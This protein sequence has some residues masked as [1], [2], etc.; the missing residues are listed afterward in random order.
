MI[1]SALLGIVTTTVAR[2][3]SA[4]PWGACV[5]RLDINAMVGGLQKNGH[6]RM[7]PVVAEASLTDRDNVVGTVY[8]DDTGFRWVEIR[9][10]ATERARLTRLLRLPYPFGTRPTPFT[11]EH[12]VEAPLALIPCRANY[13]D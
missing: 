4:P 6:T 13:G 12:D 5:G 10:D 3:D 2:A 8:F 7:V 1:V 9:A 11:A